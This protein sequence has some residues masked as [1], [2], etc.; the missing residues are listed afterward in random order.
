M[1]RGQAAGR[2]ESG[3]TKNS[4]KEERRK[5]PFMAAHTVIC[6][7]VVCRRMSNHTCLHS[8]IPSV[9]FAKA[10]GSNEIWLAGLGEGMA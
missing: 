8:R 2:N 9:L 6:A 3:G 1:S 7:F 5:G 4:G 10:H